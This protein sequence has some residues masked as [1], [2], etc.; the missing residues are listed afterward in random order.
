MSIKTV[1]VDTETGE[2][3]EQPQAKEF[4]ALLVE[5]L[6]GRTHSE[7]SDDVHELVEAVVTHGKKGELVIRFIV[8]PTT[9]GPDAPI[10]IAFET[11]LKKPKAAAQRATFFVDR[12]GN[13]VQEH[14]NQLALNFRTLPA[15]NTDLRTI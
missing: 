1:R 3:S 13:P 6:N 9:A 15:D 12:Q 8:E 7:I 5:H 2:V 11:T 14:P 4:A 10:G